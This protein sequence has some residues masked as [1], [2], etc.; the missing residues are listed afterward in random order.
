MTAFADVLAYI[1]NEATADELRQL[2]A[3]INNRHKALREQLAVD[4][5]TELHEGDDVETSGIKP[6][7]LDGLTG[8]FVRFDTSR[9]TKTYAVVKL[10]RVSVLQAGPRYVNPA[11]D[12][13]AVPLSSLRKIA[14]A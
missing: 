9:R 5:L 1:T 7:Y 3:P 10:D 11:N 13:I 8:K 4:A 2:V 14:N 12:T 6:K